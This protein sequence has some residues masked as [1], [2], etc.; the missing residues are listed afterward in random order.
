M[1]AHLFTGI[2][3]RKFHQLIWIVVVLA[4]VI[5]VIS[6]LEADKD[7]E[8]YSNFVLFVPIIICDAIYGDLKYSAFFIANIYFQLLICNVQTILLIILAATL[9]AS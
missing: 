4:A 8:D 6:A 9:F 1:S 7:S 2:V 3:D 5:G